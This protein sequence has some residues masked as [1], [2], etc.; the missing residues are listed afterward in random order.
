MNISLII[1]T[2][3]WPEAL[4]KVIQSALVQSQT[5][6]EIIIADD[7]SNDKTKDVILRIQQT[8][9][10]PII[11]SFQ[12]DKGFRAA[13]SRNKAIKQATG[14]YIVLIDG[15]M[16]LQHNFIEDHLKWAKPNQIV[17]GSRI[18]WNK[19]ISEQFLQ[20]GKTPSF[21]S[22]GVGNRK[23]LLRSGLLAKLFTKS[24][25]NTKRTRSCNMAFWRKDANLINGFD[26]RFESWGYEDTDFTQR[27]LNLKLSRIYLKFAASAYHLYHPQQSKQALDFNREI[28]EFSQQSKNTRCL[29]GLD[30]CADGP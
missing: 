3:N 6:F 1:T 21:F 13:R 25:Q 28:F 4:Q 9:D 17:Q 22:K 5:V 8:T 12:Q 16:V 27:L 10:V 7:G 26:N 2:Y 29:N 30:Q 20:T 24:M 18:T 11:H 23:N 15:D 19:S 14:D